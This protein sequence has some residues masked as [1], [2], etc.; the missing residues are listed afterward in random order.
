MHQ[1]CACEH[2]RVRACGGEGVTPVS[3][4]TDH[5]LHLPPGV[6][7]WHPRRLP[8]PL[9]EPVCK[10]TRH[11]VD[12][13]V[14]VCV[15]AFY[16]AHCSVTTECSPPT[17]YLLFHIA[18]LWGISRAS[19]RRVTWRKRLLSNQTPTTPEHHQPKTPFQPC[20]QISILMRL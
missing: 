14:N 1:L 13:C 6:C 5:T 2:T 7:L 3:A 8:C 20:N 15:F 9:P 10:G 16:F 18:I 11:N 17:P 4:S 19:Q 12:A